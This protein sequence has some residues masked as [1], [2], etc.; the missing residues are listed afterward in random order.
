VGGVTEAYKDNYNAIDWSGAKRHIKNVITKPLSHT[1]LH[2]IEPF[3]TQQGEVIGS[4]RSLREYE[5]VN[6]VRQCGND[7]TSSEKPVGWDG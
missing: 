4:R 7:Y 5:K 6:Q 1:I 3:Q 2:D